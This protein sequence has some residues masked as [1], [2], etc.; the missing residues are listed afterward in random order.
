MTGYRDSLGPVAQRL[1]DRAEGSTASMVATKDYQEM[2][3]ARKL[4]TRGVFVQF[5]TLPFFFLKARLP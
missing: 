4:A 2:R 5:G 1:I 3:A